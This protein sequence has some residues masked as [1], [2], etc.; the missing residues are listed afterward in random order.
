MTDS[1]DTSPP[2]ASRTI[3][4]VRVGRDVTDY[5]APK[6]EVNVVH[7]R[8]FDG[9]MEKFECTEVRNGSDLLWMRLVNGANRHIP[10]RSVRWFGMSIESHAYAPD[11]GDDGPD[12]LP[13]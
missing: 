4:S 10:L 1:T 9:Y 7:V 13:H 11:G 3:P 12:G 6:P 2:R 8:W 5:E